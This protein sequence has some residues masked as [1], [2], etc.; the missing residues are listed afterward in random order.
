MSRNLAILGTILGTI[1]AAIAIGV[2]AVTLR[3]G[4]DPRSESASADRVPRQSSRARGGPD[5]TEFPANAG[6]QSQ[7]SLRTWAAALDD[8]GLARAA[9]RLA[10]RLPA[11]GGDDPS[12]K[13]LICAVLKE[14]GSRDVDAALAF[15]SAFDAD[16]QGKTGDPHFQLGSPACYL[17]LAILVGHSETDA[18]NA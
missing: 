14:W 7:R 8:A 3:G 16:W 9:A 10:D 12:T 11:D 6:Q 4:D 5:S 13:A 15:V 17:K 1:P 18:G 2:V